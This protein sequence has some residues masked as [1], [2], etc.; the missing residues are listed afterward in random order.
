MKCVFG[1]LFVMNVAAFVFA[2]LRLDSENF[3]T[4]LLA[5]FTSGTGLVTAVMVIPRIIA[6]YLFNPD[7]DKEVT[8]IILRMQATDIKDKQGTRNIDD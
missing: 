1:A 6:E 2:F 7:E 5:I 3:V 4:V 8:E